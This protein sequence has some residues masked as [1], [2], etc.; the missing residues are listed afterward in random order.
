MKKKIILDDGCKE[1]TLEEVYEH[2]KNL[3]WWLVRK[4]SKDYTIHEDLFQ[5]ACVGLVKA[6]KA[7]DVSRGYKF[8]TLL[9]WKVMSE[10]K[11]A[12]RNNDPRIGKII[13]MPRDRT[14]FGYNLVYLSEVINEGPN[15]VCLED[16]IED[17]QDIEEEVVS[18]LAVEDFMDKQCMP[19]THRKIFELMRDNDG[20]ITQKQIGQAIGTS[21]A[22]VSRVISRYRQRYLSQAG[23]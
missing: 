6:Y 15:P 10:I 17:G 5:E 20:D 13:R 23:L 4:E 9:T 21:Q 11:R 19:Q 18:K 8:T 1:M 12:I 7:Y 16:A 2:F 3:I 22:M 14:R